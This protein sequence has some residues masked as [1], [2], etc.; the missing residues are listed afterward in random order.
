LIAIKVEL[1][2]VVDSVHECRPTNLVQIAVVRS[3]AFSDAFGNPIEDF[4][5]LFMGPRM[6]NGLFGRIFFFFLFF[7]LIFF[8][9]G[10]I[11]AGWVVAKII[12]GGGLLFSVDM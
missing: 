5:F 6:R 7:F 9:T 12:F 2:S 8:G 1:E 4:S 10:L 3:Q 11:T